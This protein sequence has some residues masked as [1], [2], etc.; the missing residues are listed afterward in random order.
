MASKVRWGVLGV[1]RI[2]TQKVIPGMM[3]GN[4]CEIL[5]IASR[6]LKKAEDAARELGIPKGY[7]SY[8]ALLAD[9]EIEAVYNPLPKPSPRA[10]DDQGSRGREARALRKASGSQCRRGK[11]AAF[12]S[13]PHRRENR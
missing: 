12:G 6:D 8:E 9:P 3:K 5:G 2:A 10:V 4:R 7:G 1:A 13:G 11:K